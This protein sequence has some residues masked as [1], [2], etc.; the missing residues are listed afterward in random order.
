MP[1]T[2]GM[3]QL[4]AI[5]GSLGVGLLVLMSTSTISAQQDKPKLKDAKPA[6]EDKAEARAVPGEAGKAPAPNSETP[7]VET[8]R[9]PRSCDIHID[10]R[11]NWHIHR[12]Y[13]DGDYWG[14]VSRGGDSIARDVMTGRTKVYAEA[15]FTNGTTRSWGPRWFECD[16]FSTYTWTLR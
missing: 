5:A 9:G 3:W 12:V 8:R 4:G 14:T 7:Q 13:I 10:N 15:D 2:R 6:V 1:K 11:T 16:G